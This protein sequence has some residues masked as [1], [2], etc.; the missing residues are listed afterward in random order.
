RRPYV[1]DE[2]TIV[3]GC[4]DQAESAAAG[5]RDVRA[6]RMRVFDVERVR[7][8]GATTAAAMALQPDLGLHRQGPL[9]E[10]VA[11]FWIHL[12]ADVLDDGV[13]PAVDYRLPGGLSPGAVREVLRLLLRT[14]R[15]VGLDVTIYN[16]SLD[17]T[18]A[19]GRMLASTIADGLAGNRGPPK[20]RNSRRQPAVSGVSS[21]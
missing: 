11:G 19:A 13:M 20:C 17:P 8:L 6:S 3:F 5:S 15:A 7:Q 4:R 16:P 1:R 9:A 2:D 10:G 14:G 21:D 12:D 18:W